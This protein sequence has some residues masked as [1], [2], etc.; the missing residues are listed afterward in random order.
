VFGVAPTAAAAEVLATET[1]LVAD[2][3]D[4]LLHEHRQSDRPPAPGYGL[5]AGATVI[6]DEAGTVTTPKLDEL[7]DL[8]ERHDWRVVMV[9]DPRQFSAVG[10]G[11]MYAYLVATYG[12]IELDE[13]HR[14][15]HRW[16]RDASLRLRNGDPAV[17]AEYERHGRLHGGTPEQMQI[18]ILTAWAIAR[19]RGEMVAMMAN[20]TDTVDRLNRRAQHARI[21]IGELDPTGPRLD[22]GNRLL[23]V[24]DE[25]VTRRNDRTLHTDKGTIVKNRDHWTIDTIHRDGTVTVTGRGGT[26]RLPADYTAQHLEL[27]YAQT[28][29]ATQGRTVD[30]ALLLIDG[31]TDTAGIYTP[32]TRGRG[33]NHVYVTC[34]DDETPADNLTQ[35]LGRKWIDRPAVARLAELDQ[36][37]GGTNRWRSRGS[38]TTDET[39]R[40]HRRPVPDRTP[41]PDNL[42]IGR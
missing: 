18:G 22:I 10:R 26:V 12:A 15:T 4:T 34:D 30:T 20:T 9:G 21:A 13:I 33:A 29:H 27:G 32:L 7:A 25:V 19:A 14:F 23:L 17:L 5:P 35:A 28:S 11:G 41:T 8:A 2:T 6:L 40:L 42:S 37:A 1:G 36:Q 39:D 38:S 3:L 24:G 31:P 16:E